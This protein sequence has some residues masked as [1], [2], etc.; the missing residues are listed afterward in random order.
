MQTIGKDA[1]PSII[2]AQ[3]IRSSL[4]DMD[5]NLA[6]GLIGGPGEHPEATQAYEARRLEVTEGLL[7]AAGNITYGDAERVPIRTLINGL[8]PY[9]EAAARARILHERGDSGFLIELRAADRV[10]NDDPPARRGSPRQGQ[11]CRPRP[12]LCDP[13]RVVLACPVVVTAGGRPCWSALW[14]RPRSSFT[15]GCGGC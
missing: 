9:E 4:A 5:S 15:A 13:P 8:G 11:P 1:A 2:A 3:R 6:N 12:R 7:A 14:W 10:M